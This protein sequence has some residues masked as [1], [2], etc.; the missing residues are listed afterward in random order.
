MSTY[1]KI[2]DWV[3]SELEQ[4]I[5]VIVSK[6]KSTIAGIENTFNI[7]KNKIERDCIDQINRGR[8]DD[9][10]N[11]GIASTMAVIGAAIGGIYALWEVFGDSGLDFLE[12]L[13]MFLVGILIFAAIAGAIGAVIGGIVESSVRA[14]R[15]SANRE[16]ELKHEIQRD[17]D[18]KELT[19]KKIR[20]IDAENRRCREEIEFVSNNYKKKVQEYAGKFAN[21]ESTK[22]LTVLLLKEIVEGVK[23]SNHAAYIKNINVQMWFHVYTDSIDVCVYEIREGVETTEKMH[24]LGQKHIIFKHELIRTLENMEQVD[25]LANLL[26]RFIKMQ[27]VKS[28]K[29]AVVDVACRGSRVKVDYKTPNPDVKAYTGW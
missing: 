1:A 23:K 16:L 29:M 13:A 27:L 25:A 17:K 3:K 10:D 26:V 15:T 21:S 8:K 18:I 19:E 22:K 7:R 12:R 24:V 28:D 5:D 14:T 4:R 9:G 20:D 2:N 11:L 6:N